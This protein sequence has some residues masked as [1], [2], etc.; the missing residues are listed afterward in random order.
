M[1]EAK[2]RFNLGKERDGETAAIAYALQSYRAY[3]RWL[4]GRKRI[5]NPDFRVPAL[6]GALAFREI[7]QEEGGF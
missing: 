4:Y 7:C 5:M 2:V 3:R 6:E 1:N